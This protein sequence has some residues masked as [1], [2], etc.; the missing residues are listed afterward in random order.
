M[1]PEERSSLRNDLV[2]RTFRRG[3]GA[4]PRPLADPPNC[5]RAPSIRQ[6]IKRCSSG[7]PGRWP[8]TQA[9]RLP[10]RRSGGRS[11]AGPKFVAR[12]G[13]S[14]PTVYE[15]WL[16]RGAPEEELPPEIRAAREAALDPDAP[17]TDD[18]DSE[19]LQLRSDAAIA[20]TRGASPSVVTA[21]R[22]R[23]EPLPPPQPRP[24]PR[25]AEISTI[26]QARAIEPPH[27][28]EKSTS[29]PWSILD[30]DPLFDPFATGRTPR[31]SPGGYFSGR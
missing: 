23:A 8:R 4:I 22:R 21:E 19:R 27:D 7:G 10:R 5:R 20:K 1:S 31:R 6:T 9:M 30:D 17:S 12:L 11:R 2:V 28:L 26:S 25:I 29:S 15:D 16:E 24:E 14:S 18:E 3:Y 13:F